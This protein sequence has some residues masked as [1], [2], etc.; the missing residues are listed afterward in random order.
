MLERLSTCRIM[1]QLYFDCF[2][3]LLQG[4]C[5]LCSQPT[6]PS[7]ILFIPITFREMPLQTIHHL[8]IHIHIQHH[9]IIDFLIPTSTDLITGFR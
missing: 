7:V 6:L 3:Y 2:V 4:M 1:P 8:D 9:A 5:S